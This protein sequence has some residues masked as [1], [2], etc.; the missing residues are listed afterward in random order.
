MLR[1]DELTEAVKSGVIS[2]EQAQALEGMSAAR[3]RTERFES[4]GE[5][6]VRLHAVFNEI[7]IAI[8]LLLLGIAIATLPVNLLQHSSYSAVVTKNAYYDLVAI[9]AMGILIFWGLAEYF[10]GRLKLLIPSIVIVVCLAAFASSGADLAQGGT[11]RGTLFPTALSLAIVSLH[12]LRFRLPFSLFL[13]G[14]TAVWLSVA[15]VLEAA[16]WWG[17]EPLYIKFFF[18]A[19]VVLAFGL[20]VFVWAMMF[21]VSDP[22]RSTRRA[23]CG[24][25]LHLLAAPLIVQPSIGP[26]INY[27][28]HDNYI[29]QGP[30]LSQSNIPQIMGLVVCF[31]L[32]SLVVNRRAMMFVALGYLASVITYALSSWSGLGMTRGGAGLPAFMFVGVL[33]IVMGLGWQRIRAAVMPGLPGRRWKTYLP[34]IGKKHDLVFAA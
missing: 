30:M 14:L 17:M 27:L 23:E 6:R 28:L 33:A 24:F 2:P 32:V 1:A 15:I 7:F 9:Y 10:T 20:L 21:D 31:S 22:Q 3:H 12:F 11:G 18:K 16:Q 13:I 34:P 25:W 26:F 29:A 4:D 19:K 5:E 8:G